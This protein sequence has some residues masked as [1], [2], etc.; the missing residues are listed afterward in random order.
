MFWKTRN[1]KLVGNGKDFAKFFGCAWRS[2]YILIILFV[3]YFEKFSIFK[4][5]FVNQLFNG[6]QFC[7]DIKQLLFKSVTDYRLSADSFSMH[8]N[9][10][11]PSQILYIFDHNF[12]NR[13]AVFAKFLMAE[14]SHQCGT[15]CPQARRSLASGQQLQLIMK[16]QGDIKKNNNIFVR[17][18]INYWNNTSQRK[19]GL[20][21][22]FKL[23]WKIFALHGGTFWHLVIISL[24][25]IVKNCQ[26]VDESS[27]HR[28]VH[29][30]EHTT[31]SF[32]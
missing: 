21:S 25:F 6:I 26:Q 16:W 29:M 1:G 15:Q 18:A 5:I 27:A 19:V 31:W 9:V 7:V 22:T 10:E 3:L 20:F 12:A 11:Q 24:N 28:E 30:S 17:N 32:K 8:N 2:L 4:W 13:F 14:V 23:F